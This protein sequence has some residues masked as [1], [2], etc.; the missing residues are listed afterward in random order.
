[1][2]IKEEVKM[3]TEDDDFEEPNVDNTD[4]NEDS[5]TDDDLE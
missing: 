1:M 2:P 4:E 3:N 5:I